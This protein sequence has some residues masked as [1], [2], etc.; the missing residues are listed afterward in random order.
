[1]TREQ[2]P[3]S[4]RPR[5]A[6]FTLLELLVV[7]AIIATLIGLLLPAV[8]RVRESANRIQC[9]NNLKQL[10]LALQMYADANDGKLMQVSTCVYP[11]NFIETYPQPYWFGTLTGPGQIDLQKGFLMPYIEG[12]R[13]TEQCPNFGP[14]QFQLRFQ[15][16]TS[17]YGYNYQYLGAGPSFPAGV[18][19]WVR[20]VSITSTSRTMCFADAGRIDSWDDPANP[21]LQENYYCDPPSNQFPGVHFRHLGT[22]NVAFLDGHVENMTPVDNGVPLLSPGNPYG[23]PAAADQL[24]KKVGLFDLSANDGNDTF[25]NSQQ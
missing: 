18:L 7:I 21:V 20:L 19:T 24:R 13:K 8:Q 11:T 14:G 3:R 4:P 17:G 5:P 2:T 12:N 16:A 9:A 22:A 15:G 6:A 25:Y 23:W 1:V 10:G